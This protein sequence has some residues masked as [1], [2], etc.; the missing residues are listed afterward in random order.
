MEKWEM[1]SELLE[2]RLKDC[3]FQDEVYTMVDDIIR[4]NISNI[5][6]ELGMTDDDFGGDDVTWYDE[7][8]E[9][10]RSILYN[11]IGKWLNS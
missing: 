10:M 5:E 1:A 4:T 11:R 6:K 7:L 2:E 8:M 9:D 3:E